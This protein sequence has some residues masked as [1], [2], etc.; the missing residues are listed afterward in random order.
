MAKASS[1]NPYFSGFRSY[2]FS[3]A[4][5]TEWKAR[6][7]SLFQWIPVLYSVVLRISSWL[8]VSFNPY[9]S[10]FRSYT[11]PNVIF[12]HLLIWCF[13]PYFS[14]F[15]S[16]TNCGWAFADPGNEFQSLFQWIPVLYLICIVAL[17]Y[18]AKVSIL[19]SVDSGLIRYTESVRKKC[20]IQVSIL[21]SVDS[22][23]ILI[24]WGNGHLEIYMFQS[25]FQ[26]IPVLYRQCVEERMGK[27]TEFQSL[28]QWIPVLYFL[29]LLHMAEEGISFNPYFSGFRSYTAQHI[30]T[31]ILIMCSFNPYFSGFRSYTWC[32]G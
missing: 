28:F 23:L 10:G 1:F 22:G 13:N 4:N 17:I 14:G 16:Y 31:I 20:V 15:R 7:Q 3:R 11:S 27:L 12:L 2:T 26:W 19:I 32:C 6:F 24:T 8:H 30:V 29:L 9:F 5:N 18:C 21:I 25:L